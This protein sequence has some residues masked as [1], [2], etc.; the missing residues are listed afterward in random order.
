MLICV[1][2]IVHSKLLKLLTTTWQWNFHEITHQD[3]SLVKVRFL[4]ISLACYCYLDWYHRWIIMLSLWLSI[5][6]RGNLKFL[7]ASFSFVPFKFK[8]SLLVLNWCTL[9]FEFL[10]SSGPGPG[11][12][13]VRWRS[14][15]GQEGQIWT[16]AIPYFWFAPTHPHKLFFYF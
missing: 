9:N 15:E 5:Q 12:V 8:K 16:W 13:K 7:E 3:P 1:S 10:S 4:L 6:E 11:Q 14:G 2:S